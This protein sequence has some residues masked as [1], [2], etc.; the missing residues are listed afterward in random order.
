MKIQ[1][2]CNTWICR[3]IISLRDPSYTVLLP[4]AFA[5]IKSS[6]HVFLFSADMGGW[7]VPSVCMADAYYCC[8]VRVWCHSQYDVWSRQVRSQQKYNNL[9]CLILTNIYKNAKPKTFKIFSKEEKVT[10]HILVAKQLLV[11]NYIE[12]YLSKWNCLPNVVQREI[13]KSYPS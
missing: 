1:N 12:R 6:V 5:C 4:L 13:A 7:S 8:N 10:E 11:Y 2:Q 9:P 3:I